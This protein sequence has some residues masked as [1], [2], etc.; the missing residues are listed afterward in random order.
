MDVLGEVRDVLD[1][2]VDGGPPAWCERRG[3][4][5]FLL[6]LGDDEL[7]RCEEAGLAGLPASL[8]SLAAAVRDAVRLPALGAR[9]SLGTSETRRAVRPRKA[10]EL[11]ALLSAVDGMAERADRIVDVGSGSGHLTRIAAE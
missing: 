7:G 3:W 2:R 5:G 1:E 10:E 4:T 6:G 8:A 11:A 9:V